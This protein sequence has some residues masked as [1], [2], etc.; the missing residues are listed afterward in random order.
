MI[1][2]RALAPQERRVSQRLCGAF[3]FVNGISCTCLGDFVVVLFAASL[4]VPNAVVSVLAAMQY[5]GYL[6]LPLGIPWAGRRGA[7]TGEADFWAANGATALLA[8]AAALSCRRFP[9][10]S[11]CLVVP[12]VVLFYGFRAAGSFLYTPLRGDI[13]TEEEAPGVIGATTALYSIS[14][15]ATLVAITAATR[16]WHGSGALAA[17]MGVG[18]LLGIAG[19][20]FLRVMRETGAIRDA[21][22]TRLLPAMRHA[23]HTNPALRRLALAWAM[24]NLSTMLLVPLSMLAL[25]R[26][27]GL[28]D[29]RALVCACSQALVGIAVSFANGRIC[30]RRGPKRVLVAA[31]ALYLLV[32]FVWLAMPGGGHA[33]LPAGMALFLLLGTAFFLV[34]GAANSYLLL[35]CPDKTGQVAGACAVN[36][37]A[38]GGAGIVGSTLGAWLVTRAAA[39]TPTLGTAV[40]GGTIGPYRLYFLLVLPAL[41]ISLLSCLRL[42][43]LVYGMSEGQ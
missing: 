25:K 13:S 23:F 4:G 2:G 6:M 32:P 15:V 39:W 41:A 21:A 8:V 34:N 35:A 14:G 7:A 12:C 42:K 9:V 10:A 18:A 5:A 3:N 1:L 11:C 29:S 38:G 28:D 40:F 36:L 27:C 24:L 19:S 30:R 43:P 17:I 22:R 31:A 16:R 33:A 20:F 26:G 37:T